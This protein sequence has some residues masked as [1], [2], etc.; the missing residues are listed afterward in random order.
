MYA[1][2]ASGPELKYTS[3]M[4]TNAHGHNSATFSVSSLDSAAETVIGWSA[5]VTLTGG[6][7]GGIFNIQAGSSFSLTMPNIGLTKFTGWQKRSIW[8]LMDNSGTAEQAHKN[9]QRYCVTAFNVKMTNVTPDLT[10]GGSFAM[11]HVVGDT[12]DQ[13]EGSP[14]KLYRQIASLPYSISDATDA[15]KGSYYAW[16]PEKVQDL[17]LNQ[18]VQVDPFAGN[19]MNKPFSVAVYTA[20]PDSPQVS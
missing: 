3:N 18:P 5:S 12:S 9:S 13:L 8:E 19:P 17:L 14:D 1:H 7:D 20:P 2:T 10:K 16:A 11:A 4:T 6:G 15:K